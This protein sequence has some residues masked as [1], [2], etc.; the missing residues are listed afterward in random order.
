MKIS[1]DG[2][3]RRLEALTPLL[4]KTKNEP[5]EKPISFFLFVCLFR[6]IR[7]LKL[8]EITTSQFAEIEDYKE[9]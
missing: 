6:T 4:T 2:H 8:E 7:K 1:W 9:S 3:M 5:T